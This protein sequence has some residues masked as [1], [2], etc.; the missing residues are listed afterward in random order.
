MNIF[1]NGIIFNKLLTD[2]WD[3]FLIN[4]AAR[5]KMKIELGS[6]HHNRVTSIVATLKVKCTN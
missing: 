2:D 1:L 4:D 5:Q 6:F 3:T